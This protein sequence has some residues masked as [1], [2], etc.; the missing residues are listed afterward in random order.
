M[1]I[2]EAYTLQGTPAGYWTGKAG[3][4]WVSQDRAQAFPCGAGEAERKRDLFN[5][6]SGL[7][8][9]LFSVEAV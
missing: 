4:A 5:Q 1:K 9:L 2:L 7:H 8:G 6:R 3:P